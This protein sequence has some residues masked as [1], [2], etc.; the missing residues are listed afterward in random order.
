M[1]KLIVFD[2]DGVMFNSKKAN[3]MYYNH[4][5][6]HFGLPPM[7]SAEE[8]YAHMSS[9]AD[10]VRHIFR[11]YAEP[12][13]DQV[14]GFRR[15]CSYEP[16]LGYMAIE[17]D[18]IDFLKIT[19][20]AYHLAISTNRTDTMLPLLKS[21]KI[22]HYFGKVVT[23]ATA[24]RPKPAPDGLLEILDHFQCGPQETLFI[25][26]SIIDEEHAASC[27]VPLIAFKNPSLQASYHVNNFMEILELEPFQPLTP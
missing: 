5:L 11:H 12:T 25:G 14:H 21:Y 2:C 6:S 23:A 26:D 3:C 8:D 4:L 20:G 9:V 18:L 15:S 10:S 17:A 16:F 7:D 22:E 13:L 24:R 27:Q 1:L 19:N